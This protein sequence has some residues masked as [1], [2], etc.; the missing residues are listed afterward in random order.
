MLAYSG[1]TL[2]AWRALPAAPAAVAA[3]GHTGHLEPAP[4]GGLLLY[5]QWGEPCGGTFE[6]HMY[7][8][9][10]EVSGPKLS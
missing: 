2:Q 6:E 10:P 9:S 7:L 3:G 4:D 8:A 1:I 5:A